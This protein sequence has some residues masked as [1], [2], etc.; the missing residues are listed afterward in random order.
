MTTLWTQL[1]LRPVDILGESCVPIQLKDVVNWVIVILQQGHS[2]Q[3]YMLWGN[4][5]GTVR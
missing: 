1:Y 4:L 5:G 2:V 3:V